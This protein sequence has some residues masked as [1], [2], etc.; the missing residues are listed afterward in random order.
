MGYSRD[1]QSIEDYRHTVYVAF[2][3]FGLHLDELIVSA[4]EYIVKL[5]M[6]DIFFSCR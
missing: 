5:G 2:A 3:I 6:T 1:S 4:V